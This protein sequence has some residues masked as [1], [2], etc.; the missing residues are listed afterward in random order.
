MVS[1]V[2]IESEIRDHPRARK[3]LERLRNLPVVEIEHYGE[4]HAKTMATYL[5]HQKATV[6][7]ANTIIIFH[8]C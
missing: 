7:V 8:T 5:R 1:S 3:L 2:Y 6:L 4:L